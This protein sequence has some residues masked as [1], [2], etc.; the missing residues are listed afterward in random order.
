MI[1]LLLIS[2]LILFAHEALEPTTCTRQDKTIV[3]TKPKAGGYTVTLPDASTRSLKAPTV[4]DK[5][6]PEKKQV[7]DIYSFAKQGLNLKI[8]RPETKG[9]VKKPFAIWKG[10]N[11]S[12]E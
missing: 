12:C 1:L 5:Y 6:D 3:I 11:Y 2:P 9:P 10:E 4:H 8:K 7:F